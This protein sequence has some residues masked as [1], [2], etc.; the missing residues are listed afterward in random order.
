MKSLW[1]FDGVAG[2]GGQLRSQ[3]SVEGAPATGQKLGDGLVLLQEVVDGSDGYRDPG[4]QA[5]R[6]AI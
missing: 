6:K 3:P 2:A 5:E 4:N 1:G